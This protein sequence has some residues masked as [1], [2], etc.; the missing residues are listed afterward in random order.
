MGN[1]A[2][3]LNLGNRFRPPWFPEGNNILFYRDGGRELSKIYD[4][5]LETPRSRT[6]P[7][8]GFR[9]GSVSRNSA[10]TRWGRWWVSPKYSD[11]KCEC[12]CIVLTYFWCLLPT[13]IRTFIRE[14]ADCLN[15][16]ILWAFICMSL[17]HWI[18]W[19]RSVFA[20]EINRL[21]PQHEMLYF[22]SSAY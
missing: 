2:E 14:V 17:R 1:F 11:Q 19:Y 7:T 20:I 22:Y 6:S 9:R 8:S 18:C 16:I 4:S 10:S 5:L 21:I 15:V 3:N 13:S 12:C